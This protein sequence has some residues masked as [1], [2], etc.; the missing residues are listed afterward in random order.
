VAVL[1]DRLKQIRKHAPAT[2]SKAAD[3]GHSSGSFRER[4]EYLKGLADQA[5]P[6]TVAGDVPPEVLAR[7]MRPSEGEDTA[8]MSLEDLRAGKSPAGPS[9]IDDTR[10]VSVAAAA[11]MV[12]R[13]ADPDSTEEFTTTGPAVPSRRRRASRSDRPVADGAPP[14]TTPADPAKSPDDVVDQHDVLPSLDSIQRRAST[15]DLPKVDR[16]TAT[17]DAS[18][19][20]ILLRAGSGELRSLPH[21]N[22]PMVSDESGA[23]SRSL[24]IQLDTI[25]R[26]NRGVRLISAVGF[27]VI[28]MLGAVGATV[29][30]LFI[31]HDRFADLKE[32]DK[33]A[34]AELEAGHAGKTDF[35]DL[36]GYKPDE[37]AGLIELP[38]STEPETELT[39]DEDTMP[40][41]AEDGN[42]NLA[43]KKAPRI[44]GPEGKAPRTSGPEEKAPR[45]SGPDEKVA[46]AI[47]ETSTPVEKT[48]T[49]A[50]PEP[51]SE[52]DK[53]KKSMS[54]YEA[55]ASNRPKTVIERAERTEVD[56][57]AASLPDTLKREDLV[58]GF[59]NVR[60]SADQCLERH[61]KRQGRLPKGKVKV[62]VTIDGD[63]RV[64]G[65]N[66][67]QEVSNT[68][69]DS[70]MRAHKSRWRFPQFSGKPLL[71]SRVF[72]L[73]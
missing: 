55:M 58:R 12:A 10:Q 32:K 5:G 67:D 8:Q 9:S 71:V 51:E 30:Y 39:F 56:D 7:S 54:V 53:K 20:R 43:D 72:V 66:M 64:S 62:V 26:Q 59:R 49:V 29:A 27:V 3:T 68:L 57:A 38:E 22:T 36:K 69:F 17:S 2:L 14:S 40:L 16:L 6:S 60:R 34:Q 23:M 18:T 4:V 15:V 46:L 13:S 48:N 31:D 42:K 35:R 65:L 70:C 33:V 61:I 52:A 44:S 24:L 45:T 73:Q 11:G 28:L 25:K 50:A 63:G 19:P 37:F 21:M 41:V 1:R 47:K